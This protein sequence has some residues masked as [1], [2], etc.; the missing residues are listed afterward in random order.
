MPHVANE[1][2]PADLGTMLFIQAIVVSRVM[3]WMTVD[4]LLP[5]DGPSCQSDVVETIAKVGLHMYLLFMVPGIFNRSKDIS[6]S[7]KSSS[8]QFVEDFPGLKTP[9]SLQPRKQRCVTISMIQVT[10]AKQM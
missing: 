1:V 4:S 3:A 6:Y 8:F 9:A 10:A 7:V 5:T 2:A